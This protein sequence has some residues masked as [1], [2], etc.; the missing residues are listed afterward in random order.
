MEQT[1]IVPRSQEATTARN[2]MDQRLGAIELEERDY[3]MEYTECCD[4][5]PKGN[6]QLYYTNL[7]H[8]NFRKEI[9]SGYGLF[10]I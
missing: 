9:T 5:D 8:C 2:V 4:S 3:V 7:K 6:I 10:A 1:G